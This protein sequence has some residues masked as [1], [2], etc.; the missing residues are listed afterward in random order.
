[1]AKFVRMPAE[2][3]QAAF[4]ALASHPVALVLEQLKNC[5]IEDDAPPPI[6]A[7]VETSETT[8]PKPA[9]N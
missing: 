8:E 2:L 7:P 1:M 9:K 4:A 3:A 6:D 5:Q